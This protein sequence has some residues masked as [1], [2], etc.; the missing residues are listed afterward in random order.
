MSA[1]RCRRGLCD[2]PWTILG[3]WLSRQLGGGRYSSVG[4]WNP[5][6][7]L[8]RDPGRSENLGQRPSDVRR[9]LP[10]LIAVRGAVTEDITAPF[11]CAS[12]RS[13]KRFIATAQSPLLADFV[14]KVS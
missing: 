4:G 1:R 10:R 3:Q 9:T 13:A 14:A 11:G 5:C 12:G 7:A 8:G 6:R 2:A